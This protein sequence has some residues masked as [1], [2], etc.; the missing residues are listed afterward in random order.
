M[1]SFGTGRTWSTGCLIDLVRPGDFVDDV[2]KCP[3][4]TPALSG[5]R[6]APN[7]ASTSWRRSEWCRSESGQ[8]ELAARC[9]TGH[10]AESGN[11]I[12]RRTRVGRVI[13]LDGRLDQTVG[14]VRCIKHLAGVF[15]TERREVNQEMMLV[16]CLEPDLGDVREFLEDGLAHRVQGLLQ[17]VAAVSYT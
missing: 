16:R 9:Q 12:P 3:F 6:R 15:I 1:A 17:R 2:M 7:G 8:R 4:G 10:A 5:S 11:G 14:P 13:T